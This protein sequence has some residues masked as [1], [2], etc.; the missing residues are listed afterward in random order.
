VQALFLD[1]LKC[2]RVRRLCDLD[3]GRERGG[4]HSNT[5][6]YGQGCRKLDFRRSAGD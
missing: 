3:V 5:P 2:G 6:G 1:G 4:C